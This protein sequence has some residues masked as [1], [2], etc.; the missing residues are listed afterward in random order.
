MSGDANQP[1]IVSGVRTAIARAPRGALRSTRPDDIA[2]ATIHAAICGLDGLNPAEVED[3]IL[4]CASP[5]AEQ[6][7]NIA[8]VA[9]LR[10]GLPN[11]VPGLTLNRFCASGLEAI[12]T[13]ASKI[14][15]GQAD[16]IIAGGTESMSM[17]QF[18]GETT[19]PNPYLMEHAPDTY[20]SMGL[21]V[22]G[23]V[24]EFGITRESAD[25]LS[26]ESHR[27]AL[28]AQEAGKFEAEIV[29]VPVKVEEPAGE[30]FK[31]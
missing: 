30:G 3:V 31:I 16:T 7:L 29:P 10:A 26:L 15:S 17:V 4:G 12:A 19:R 13:A 2:A 6:G 27:K 23:L 9:A 21:S 5:E 20:L 8:R 18:M 28:A 25:A 22:E 1:V 24:K 14:G 11:S